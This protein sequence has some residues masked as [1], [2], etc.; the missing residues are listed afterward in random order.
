MRLTSTSCDVV[1]PHACCHGYNR[2]CCYNYNTSLLHVCGCCHGYKVQL[3]FHFSPADFSVQFDPAS[4]TV[5]E[6]DGVVSI[7]IVADRAAPS[8]NDGAALFYTMDGTATGKRY[9][10]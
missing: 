2:L 5:D 7:T 3:C 1:L 9:S 10:R 4:Y 8:A 6:A